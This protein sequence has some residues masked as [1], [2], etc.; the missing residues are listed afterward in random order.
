MHCV[1]ALRQCKVQDL[2]V[3]F[4]HMNHARIVVLLG[5]ATSRL[6]AAQKGSK[7]LVITT[8]AAAA[9]HRYQACGR[10]IFVKHP[11]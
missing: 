9:A 3:T 8:H 6:K 10:S 1:E 2:A 7:V 11:N 5:A 4:T